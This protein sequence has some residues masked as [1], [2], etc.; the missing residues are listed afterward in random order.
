MQEPARFA[1]AGELRVKEADLQ[2]PYDDP[3]FSRRHFVVEVNPPRCRLMDLKSRNGTYVNGEEVSAAECEDDPNRTR[4][5][6][7]P[8]TSRTAIGAR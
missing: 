4:A 2:L 3:Y 6:I 8:T 7:T 1:G 5:T